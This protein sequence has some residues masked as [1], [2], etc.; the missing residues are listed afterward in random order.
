MF[1]FSPCYGTVELGLILSYVAIYSNI[2][3]C[4]IILI[5]M[6]PEGRLPSHH[7]RVNQ[8]TTTP[9][10]DNIHQLVER[11]EK[12]QS[13]VNAMLDFYGPSPIGR[14]WKFMGYMPTRGLC[15]HITLITPAPIHGIIIHYEEP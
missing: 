9:L 6:L 8:S 1:S 2:H 15:S 13:F 5:E 10:W 7:E 14:L 12:S 3:Y 4:F 11:M